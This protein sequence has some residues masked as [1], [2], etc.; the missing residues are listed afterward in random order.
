MVAFHVINKNYSDKKKS[1]S[2]IIAEINIKHQLMA[3]TLN[4]SPLT[5]YQINKRYNFI[6]V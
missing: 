2:T 6:T 1:P 5:A 3:E 4:T